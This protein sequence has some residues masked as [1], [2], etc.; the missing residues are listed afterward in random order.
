MPVRILVVMNTIDAGGAET[1]VMKLFRCIDKNKFVFD[2][3]IN[4]A[5]SNFYEKEITDL[6]GRIYRG[7]SKSKEPLNCFCFIKKTVK[8]GNYKTIFCLATHPVGF[9]DL[10]A[11]RL[12]GA[13]RILTRSTVAVCG[14]RASRTLAALSR[15]FIRSLSSVYIAPS[16]EAGSW[17]FG[18]KAVNAG[19]V[20]VLNN[21]IDV[22]KFVYSDVVRNTKRKELKI[23]EEQFVVGHIGRLSYQ[24]NHKKL[25]YVFNEILKI[26]P[27][28][29][30]VLIGEGE[31]R[32]E[33][34]RQVKEL[35]IIENVMFLGLRKDIPELL[36]A[37]DEFIL[38]SFYEGL[39]NTIVEA[40][41]TGLPCILADTISR[42]V[43]FTNLVEMISLDESDESWAITAVNKAPIHRNDMTREITEA[44][45][46]IEETTRRF[47]EMTRI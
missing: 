11:C 30:L 44:G 24:K 37:F 22:K 25:L 42:E 15:P 26:R 27:N 23:G 16:K 12:G 28:S 39:P 29:V 35:G 8:E 9:W 45:F 18:T 6:G 21:G 19:K 32:D 47:I 33:V 14:T 36:M 3:L 1:F 46:S 13:K 4:K 2:F 10:L 5:N 41:A 38:P 17:L 31:K 20:I 43:Q 7:F 40:Q 34:E